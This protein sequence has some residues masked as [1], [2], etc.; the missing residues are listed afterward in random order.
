M[1]ERNAKFAAKWGKMQNE[2]RCG[3]HDVSAA[4]LHEDYQGLNVEVT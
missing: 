3:H 2:K 1:K 4:Y